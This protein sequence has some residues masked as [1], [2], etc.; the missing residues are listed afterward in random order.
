MTLNQTP[1]AERI[2]IGIF[3]KRNAGKSS[4]IN[5]LAGQPV[6][7]VSDF[8]GTTT[9]PVKKAM[10]LLPLGPVVLTDTPGLDDTGEL[11]TL[12][13][14][15]TQQI[16]NTTDIALLVIDGQL[17]ITEE[18][19][20]ILQQIRQKQIPFVIA[21]NKMDLTIASPV[22]PDEISREQILYVSAA[23]GTHIHELKELLAKQ[24]G[25]TPKTRK[26]VGDLI[27]P[28]DFVVLVIPIDKAAPK[29]RLILP[30]QQTIRDILD[31]G[32]TAIAVRDSEL[33]ETLKNLGRTPALVITDSQVFDAVA[34]IVPKEV[35]LTSFSILF[36]RY[37]GNLAL[38]AKG[39]QTLG[40]LKDKDRVLI[41]EG[42]THHRQCEDIGTVK[43]PRMLKQF[44]QKDLQFTFTS[45]TDFPSDLSPYQVIIHCGGCTLNERE[46][47]YRLKCAEDA[48]LPI[49]N[50]GTAIAYMKGILERSIEIF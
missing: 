41:C 34:K 20:R 38:A 40:T 33:S 26:I 18:D 46:M 10:E 19:T 7:I 4:L 2:H 35:P 37:K 12:R 16:L 29:G 5:A 36:A 1:S 50:Y 48:K 21:V 17:G 13:I 49:T 32:A 23:A 14:E 25:Q 24:L 22:L 27:H 6:S 30:Q 42:C 47:R 39:A 8:K 3:G 11:G 28:G 9:D 31:H 15:K 45:G 43:L 44:T